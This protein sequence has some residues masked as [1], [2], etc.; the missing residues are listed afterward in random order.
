MTRTEAQE[1]EGISNE[2]VKFACENNKVELKKMIWK[3]KM[4]AWLRSTLLIQN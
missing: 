2:I 4:A 1:T 3:T